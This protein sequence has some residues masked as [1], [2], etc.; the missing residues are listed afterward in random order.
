MNS[1]L[2]RI[3]LFWR[4]RTACICMILCAAVMLIVLTGLNIHAGTGSALPVGLITHAGA[5]GTEH[6]IGNS[7][8]QAL[9]SN[10]AL[11]VHEGTESELKE[12]LADGYIY[13]IIEF[14]PEIDRL[15]ENGEYKGIMT[16]HSAKDSPVAT[17]I[18]DIAAGCAMDEICMHKAY[19]KYSSLS[20][21]AD[22]HI[23]QAEYRRLLDSMRNEG[24]YE[25]VF[26][27][28]Y[29]DTG[30][31]IAKEVT[32]ALIYRQVIAGLTA[33]LLMLA[34]FCACGPVSVEYASGIRNRL[35]IS[36]TSDLKL[37]IQE[38]CG[39]FTCCAPVAA[40]AGFLSGAGLRSALLMTALNLALLAAAVAMYYILS[41]VTANL[42][43]Y[44]TAGTV[45]LIILSAAGFISIFEGLAGKQVLAHTP[46]AAYIRQYIGFFLI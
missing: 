43:A 44:Q 38:A 25:F 24:G 18:G 45:L 29:V 11:N 7:I 22:D 34:A 35:K 14:D 2:L 21:A 30:K 28:D 10:E 4:D 16:M 33:M 32:N 15:I 40:L 12:L 26:D 42:F 27:T 20:E 37:F 31:Q 5:D 36:S 23:A 6:Y 41:A 19:N 8:A 3:K 39:L 46:I 1:Y 9:R 13:C 17:I